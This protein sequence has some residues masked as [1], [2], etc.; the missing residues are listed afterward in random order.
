MSYLGTYYRD[1]HGDG[2]SHLL[3]LY[4]VLVAAAKWVETSINGRYGNSRTPI[5]LDDMPGYDLGFRPVELQVF[6][7]VNREPMYRNQ[8]NMYIRV[9]NEPEYM[10]VNAFGG[11]S[12]TIKATRDMAENLC[13][14]TGLLYFQDDSDSLDQDTMASALS[15]KMSWLQ[16]KLIPQPP[17]ESGE[18]YVTVAPER[19]TYVPLLYS[20]ELGE[21]YY[22]YVDSLKVF[23]RGSGQVSIQLGCGDLVAV[24]WITGKISWVGYE[25][26]WEGNAE[27]FQ[28]DQYEKL[29][30]EQ[31]KS[32]LYS[33]MR[34]KWE[35]ID[36]QR[37]KGNPSMR[38]TNLYEQPH[39]VVEKIR[40][41]SEEERD[42]Y[43]ASHPFPRLGELTVFDEEMAKKSVYGCRYSGVL[44]SISHIDVTSFLE[45]L[46]ELPCGSL[47]LAPY[48]EHAGTNM[49]NF[50]W[51]LRYTGNLFQSVLQTTSFSPWFLSMLLNSITGGGKPMDP[52]IRS[53]PQWFGLTKPEFKALL[54][55]PSGNKFVFSL[56]IRQLKPYSLKDCERLYARVV[57][58]CEENNMSRMDFAW[59]YCSTM[60]IIRGKYG[61]VLLRTTKLPRAVGL[62]MSENL[63]KSIPVTDFIK[64]MSQEIVP[65]HPQV[66][67][68]M[69]VWSLLKDYNRMAKEVIPSCGF[70][71][72][73]HILP[74][75]DSMVN[76]YNQ[77]KADKLLAMQ[78][79]GDNGLNVEE[80]NAFE[81]CYSGKP[82]DVYSDAAFIMRAP[83]SGMDLYEEGIILNH[84]VGAYTDAIISARG[85]MLIYFLRKANQPDN[86]LV[87][88]QINRSKEKTSDPFYL[89]EIAGKGNRLPTDAEKKFAEDWLEHL[90]A[91]II[92]K[93]KAN[94]SLQKALVDSYDKEV[95]NW[96][97]VLGVPVEVLPD[98]DGTVDVDENYIRL[99]DAA[100]CGLAAFAAN[101]SY[102]LDIDNLKK[103]VSKF[104][105]RLRLSNEAASAF[106][107]LVDSLPSPIS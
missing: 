107:G 95:I 9:W 25:V 18:I 97:T 51:T 30:E 35:F 57:K 1:F 48:K 34:E 65:G 38:K 2:N 44:K 54:S 24:N 102:R 68:L 3:E 96:L 78:E 73:H 31:A 61:R 42:M 87:T 94:G 56:G 101:Q 74:A 62:Y 22:F 43:Y 85:S 92:E 64:Y 76:N 17:K 84:C 105:K 69:Q 53:L 37:R 29:K 83:E 28:P 6:K 21:M 100:T 39:D 32:K 70:V 98:Y 93:K 49:V 75:H 10:Y 58:E 50:L 79:A 36:E 45:I 103:Q 67:T 89:F 59:Q 41:E 99:F 72:P 8:S 63:H 88:V 5:Q 77:I 13:K 66:G 7:K 71:L 104:C 80:L 11:E 55:E 46:Y 91:Y 4:D 82:A 47:Y 20:L 14:N 26:P 52:S 86:P 19:N 81:K 16:P 33:I 27:L 106:M 90:N 40:K 60:S 15:L 23:K 12:D